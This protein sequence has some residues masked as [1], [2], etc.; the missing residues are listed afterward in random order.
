MYNRP[1]GDDTASNV[2]ITAANLVA[3]IAT[4]HWEDMDRKWRSICGLVILAI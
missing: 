4:Q 2:P 3:N 1:I